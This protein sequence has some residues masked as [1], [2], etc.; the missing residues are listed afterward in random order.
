MGRAGSHDWSVVGVGG[1]GRGSTVSAT[2]AGGGGAGLAGAAG[3]GGEQASPTLVASTRT[4]EQKARMRGVSA[5][6]GD[7]TTHSPQDSRSRAQ[8]TLEDTLLLA[9]GRLS[10]AWSGARD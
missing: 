10:K 5:N 8:R 1:G 2:G 9:L 4:K 6:S 7:E 3:G